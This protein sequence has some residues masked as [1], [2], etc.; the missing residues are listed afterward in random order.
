ME[1]TNFEKLRVYQLA[2]ILADLIWEIVLGW[3]YQETDRKT[4]IRCS[5]TGAYT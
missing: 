3:D 2:E 1:K 4:K 5:R